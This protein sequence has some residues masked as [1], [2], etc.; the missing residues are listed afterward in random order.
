MADSKVTVLA[1]NTGRQRVPTKSSG[2]NTSV[3]AN[4]DAANSGTM[5][6]LA[7]GLLASMMLCGA[8][9]LHVSA[10]VSALDAGY[11][12]AK[13]EDEHRLLERDNV[14]LKL[15]LATLRSAAH[16]EARARTQLLM[17]TP[18]AQV[19]FPVGGPV[20]PLV[21]PPQKKTPTPKGEKSARASKTPV[22][23]VSHPS[24]SAATSSAQ[25]QTQTSTTIGNGIALLAEETR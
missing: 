5:G 9:L 16:I 10:K 15:Q 14:A 21:R 25:K 19:V 6:M 22:A 17:T 18:A 23:A 13:L 8:G 24:A 12:L 11:K 20:T 7:V 1:R 3:G 4:A 2:T